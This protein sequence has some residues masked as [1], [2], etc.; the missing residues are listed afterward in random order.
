MRRMLTPDFS[1]RLADAVLKEA[2]VGKD[3]LEALQ[4]MPFDRLV[5]AAQIAAKKVY[6]TPDYS[7]PLDFGRHC[8][9]NPWAPDGRR[10]ASCPSIRS[11]PGRPPRRPAC[12]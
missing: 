6:P 2:G 3:R 9:F 5:A 4:D 11:G 10:H 8:E 12:R 1:A 7:R